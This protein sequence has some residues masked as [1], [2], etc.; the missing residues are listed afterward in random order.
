[1]RLQE[2]KWICHLAYA[3]ADDADLI[4]EQKNVIRVLLHELFSCFLPVFILEANEIE[5][6]VID[7]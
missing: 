3:A 4:L 7:V 6:I 5:I 1:M 2:K